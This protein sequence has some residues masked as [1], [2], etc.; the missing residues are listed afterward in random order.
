[1]SQMDCSTQVAVFQID[2]VE[3]T[4]WVEQMWMVDQ[5]RVEPKD[6]E[7]LQKEKNPYAAASPSPFTPDFANPRM[8]LDPNLLRNMQGGI[9][10]AAPSP[11]ATTP[12]PFAQ[13]TFAQPTFAQ[14]TFAQP[15]FGQPSYAQPNAF[16]QPGVNQF[17]GTPPPAANPFATSG[18]PNPFAT[19]PSPFTGSFALTAANP[20]PNPFATTP[21]LTGPNPFATS[22]APAGNHFF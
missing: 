20:A 19:T 13:P 2:Q 12:N 7:L 1:M 15:S 18:A 10:G 9:G 16:A 4:Y 11:F 8:T 21:A 22:P 6:L 14:P 17:G 5:K 3:Q